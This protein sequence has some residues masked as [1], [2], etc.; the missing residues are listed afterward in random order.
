[1]G[2]DSGLNTPGGGLSAVNITLKVLVQFA[3]SI[4]D[5]P[6]KP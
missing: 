1:M 3:Y 4:R 5:D 2:R 6:T